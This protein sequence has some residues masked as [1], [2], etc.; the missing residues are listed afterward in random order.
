[1]ASLLT[2]TTQALAVMPHWLDSV[3]RRAARHQSIARSSPS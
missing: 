2:V 1:V 3:P